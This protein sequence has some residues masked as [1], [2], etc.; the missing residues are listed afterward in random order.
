[1]PLA[2]SPPPPLSRLFGLSIFDEDN[3]GAVDFREFVLSTWNCCTMVGKPQVPRFAIYVV[4][5]IITLLEFVVSG[6]LCYMEHTELRR[7]RS[8]TVAFPV[9]FRVQKA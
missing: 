3:S 5:W 6:T 7:A 8:S 4:G 2:C 1:M 9:M